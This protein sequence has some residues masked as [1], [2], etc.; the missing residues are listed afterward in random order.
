MSQ[1]KMHSLAKIGKTADVMHLHGSR[2]ATG[3]HDSFPYSLEIRKGMITS[4]RRHID[5]PL[6]SAPESLNVDLS[7]YLLLPGFINAHDHLQYALHPRLGHPPYQNY[8]QW[9]E[10]IHA[11][12]AEQIATY[13]SVPRDVRLW[14]GGIRNLLCGVT[15][16]CHHDQLWP[17]LSKPDFPVNVVQSYGWAHSLAWGGDLC[18]ASAERPKGSAF[19]I[20]ACEGIDDLAR[21]ELFALDRL[22]LLHE[23]TALIH[24]LAIDHEGAALLRKRKASLVICPSSNHFLFATL[25]NMNF[26]SAIENVS[27]GNDSPLTAAGDLLDEARFAKESCHLSSDQVYR[28]VSESPAKLLR[29]QDKEGTIQVSGAADLVAVFDDGRNAADRLGA[30]SVEDVELVMV[31]GQIRL[32][33]EPVWKRLPPQVKSGLVPLRIGEQIRWLR[34]PVQELLCEAEAVLGV[35]EVKLGSRSIR[36]FDTSVDANMQRDSHRAGA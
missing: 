20:H 10:D 26:L 27:L 2:C 31:R 11:T 17:E 16:V 13:K 4:L 35:G 30:L 14:W 8:I 9:G 5:G 33:S 21:E 7:G 22:G 1:E 6:P 29:L 15:T 25:P 34:A 12:C 23:S 24:G 3:P 32:T 36:S 18:A 19:L 28:M